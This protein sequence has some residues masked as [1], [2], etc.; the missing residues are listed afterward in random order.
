MLLLGLTGCGEAPPARFRLNMVEMV[1]SEM[2]RDQ[3]IGIANVLTAAFGTPDEPF[4]M[5]EAELDLKKLKAAAGAVASDQLGNEVGLYRRHCA[6]CHGI[7]GDGAGPT[8]AFLNPYPRDYRQGVYKFK[9]T[10]RVA[11]PTRDDLRRVLVE[12]VPGTAMPSFR[13]LPDHQLDALIEYVIYLSMRGEL[14]QRLVAET[15]DLDEGERID[16][17]PEVAEITKEVVAEIGEKWAQASDLVINPDA[18]LAPPTDRSPAELAVSIAAGRELFHG[19][20]A[21]CVKCHGTTALGD[22]E[23]TDFDDWNKRLF[24]LSE[25]KPDL[26][27][28]ELGALPVRTIRPRNLRQGI[29]RGGRRPLDIYRRI[30]AG[31]NGSPMPGSAKASPDAAVGLAAEEIWNLVD[32][33]QSLPFD[34]LSLPPEQLVAPKRERL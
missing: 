32:Y 13:L 14:E 26:D 29:Y 21:A 20:R 27:L 33:V 8:A 4:A 6:H 2:S 1:S 28:A 10:E 7:S 34:S 15:F 30:H 11:R 17:L 16:Q 3:Q 22:G 19:E 12:G 31:I 9:S 18:D 5:A 23:T 25:S 24:K